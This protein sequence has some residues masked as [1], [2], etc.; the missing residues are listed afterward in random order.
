MQKLSVRQM[1]RAKSPRL[2]ALLPDFVISALERLLCIDRIE[3][4]LDIGKDMQ[5]LEFIDEIFTRLDITY[6]GIW[7]DEPRKGRYVFASNHPFGGMDGIILASEVIAHLGDVRSISNDILLV[8]E[9]L[10]PILLPVNKHGAQSRTAAETYENTF[11][12]DMPI[13]TFPAGLCSR[14]IKGEITDLEWKTNFTKKAI[15][16]NRHVVPVHFEGRLSNRFYNIY[17]FRK[18]F[19]IKANIEMLYLVDEMFRQRGKSFEVVIGDPISPEELAAVG[20]P[21]EQTEYVRAKSY[22]LAPKSGK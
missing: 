17:S 8:L 7:E 19:G 11:A 13:Q 9:P 5:P 18:F 20:T 21:R 16:H 12:S 14:R 10:A 1:I 6:E 15:Q 4:L 3:E 22:A 2:D